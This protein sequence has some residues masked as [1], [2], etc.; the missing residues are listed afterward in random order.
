MEL[1][2]KTLEEF[3]I[4]RN[5]KIEGNVLSKSEM[6]EAI[7]LAREIIEGLEFIHSSNLI[8]RDLKPSNIMLSED[9]L[10][11]KIGDFGLVT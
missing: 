7:T 8:H 6:K 5:S 2:S 10:G 9:I 4:E 3:I 1:C 11:V